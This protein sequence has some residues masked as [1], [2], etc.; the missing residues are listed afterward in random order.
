MATDKAQKINT[1]IALVVLVVIITV[2]CVVGSITY[3]RT[4]EILQ[5]QAEVTEYR[6]SSKVPG[7]IME[8]RVKEGQMVKAGD[9]LAIIEAPDVEAKL[10]QAEAVRSAAIAMSDKAEAGARQEQI[11]SAYELWQKAKVNTEIMQKSFRRVSNLYKEGVVS[12]QK[13]DEAKA[14]YDAAVST[15]RAAKSQYDMAKDGAQKEDKEMAAANVLQAE[16][17]VVEVDSYLKETILTA[18]SDGEVTDIF[19]HAGELVG[20]G[21]PIMNIAVMDDIWVSFNVREDNLQKMQMGQRLTAEIPALG[22]T[23]EMEVKY[24]KDRG[25]YAAW[26]ATKQTG[27]YDLK[28][29]EVRAVPVGNVDG[30]RPG[31][32]VLYRINEK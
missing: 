30:I 19:P 23:D 4:N 7:R 27:Q 12:E 24:M 1:F 16:G 18:Y 32:T 26:K 11:Q 2:V 28:T 29:F 5:G 22:T 6:V 31:M 13:Y 8:Y 10:A 17:V 21:A 20:T 25:E 15:E 14:Q 9:T 3:G